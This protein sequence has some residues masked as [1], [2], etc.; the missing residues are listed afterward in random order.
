MFSSNK[1]SPNTTRY[2]SAI[3]A[4]LRKRQIDVHDVIFVFFL[5]FHFV[6]FPTEVFRIEFSKRKTIR[7]DIVEKR[8]FSLSYL[9]T[10]STWNNTKNGIFWTQSFFSLERLLSSFLIAWHAASI[11]LERYREGGAVGDRVFQK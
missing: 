5:Q 7:T 2:T 11:I 4:M 8:S 6:H 9:P 1:S 10:Y 3:R